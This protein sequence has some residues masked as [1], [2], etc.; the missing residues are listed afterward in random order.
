MADRLQAIRQP[1]A[2][3]ALLLLMVDQEGGEV[4]RLPG[5]PRRSPPEI[6]ATGDPATR[7]ARAAGPRRR[8]APAA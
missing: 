5:A 8:S 3:R 1:A 4:K 6:A 7:S 2:V